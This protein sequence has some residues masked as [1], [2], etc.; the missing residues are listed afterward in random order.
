MFLNFIM[1]PLVIFN[2][3]DHSYWKG[4]D[5]LMSVSGL[6]KNYIPEFDS[7]FASKRNVIKNQFPEEYERIKDIIKSRNRKGYKWWEDPDLPNLFKD[8]K[9][10]NELAEKVKEGWNE[11]GLASRTRGTMFHEEQE[12]QDIEIGQVI[13]EYTGA[14]FQVQNFEKQYDNQSLFDDLSQLP[15][16]YYPELL[17][18]N[19][20]YGI[21]GQE[22]RVFIQTSGNKRYAW[23]GDWKTDESINMTPDFFTKKMHPPIDHLDHLN[24]IGYALKG[25]TYAWMLEQFGFEVAGISISNIEIDDDLQIKKKTFH[26][27]PYLKEE[28]IAVLNHWKSTS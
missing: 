4:S 2:N 19:T 3:S 8:Q 26:K 7:D 28:V 10:L 25:S 22:D 1:K 20:R 11:K 16:G 24:G 17:L 27:L 15:D 12:L 14:A 23:F 9:L 18:F 13:N 5:K 21:A 6:Y